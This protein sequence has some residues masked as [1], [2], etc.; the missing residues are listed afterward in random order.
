MILGREV[1]NYSAYARQ[2]GV[3]LHTT[4]GIGY[5]VPWRQVEAM[6]L[7]AAERATGLKRNPEARPD[8]P[9]S[10]SVD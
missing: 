3:I 9:V 2:G 5:E 8:P 6:L 1:I 10:P 4:V 7:L